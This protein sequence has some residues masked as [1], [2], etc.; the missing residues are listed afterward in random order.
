[1]HELGSA[2]ASGVGPS[3][4]SSLRE[5]ALILCSNF[6][7]GDTPKVISGPPDAS[8]PPRQNFIR[9][10]GAVEAARGSCTDTS[11]P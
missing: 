8:L 4:T 3:S 10:V 7:E 5:E 9:M 2:P 6:K 11:R 1:M